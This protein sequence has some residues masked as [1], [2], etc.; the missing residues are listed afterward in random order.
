MNLK[1]LGERKKDYWIAT[2]LEFNLVAQGRTFE[3]A[4]KSLEDAISSYIET[5]FD[6]EDALSIPDLLYRPA[7]MSKRIRFWIVWK[8]QQIDRWK[9]AMIHPRIPVHACAST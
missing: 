7:P 4:C 9:A 6:T 1:I 8:C 3:D 2:C 5:V